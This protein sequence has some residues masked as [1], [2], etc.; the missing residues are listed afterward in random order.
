MSKITQKIPNKT[1]KEI[2]LQNKARAK[3]GLS[4]I[5]VKIRQCMRCK[6]SFESCCNYICN[7][8]KKSGLVSYED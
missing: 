7:N 3:V 2:Q 8:C 4:P 1:K 6:K 5:K